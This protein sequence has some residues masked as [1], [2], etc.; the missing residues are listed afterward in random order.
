MLRRFELAPRWR[1]A[2]S[3]EDLQRR[4][5]WFIGVT[6]AVVMV[7]RGRQNDEDDQGEAE[8]STPGPSENNSTFHSDLRGFMNA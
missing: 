7:T 4:L 2:R 3:F 6:G 8:R 1:P 5:F